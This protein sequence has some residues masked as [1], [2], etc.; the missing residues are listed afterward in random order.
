MLRRL[1]LFVAV[2]GLVAVTG[3]VRSADKAAANGPTLV[4]RLRSIDDILADVKYF[5]SLAGREADAKRLDDH[6]HSA[7]PN[8]IEGID[9]K[10]PIG[11]YAQLDPD[12]NLMESIPVALVPLKDEKAFVDLIEKVAHVTPKLDSDGIYSMT[13]ENSPVS[14]YMLI[15]NKYAYITARE[16]SALSKEKTLGPAEVFPSGQMPL[17]SATFRMDQ[18]PDAFKQIAI[19]QG[20][21]RLS[22]VEDDKPKGETPAQHAAKV[23]TAKQV[24]SGFASILKEGGPLSLSLDVNPESGK[25][26]LQVTLAARPDTA[27][28]KHIAALG[29]SESLFARLAG[30]DSAASVLVHAA[31]PKSVRESLAPAIDEGIKKGLE[32]E[33]DQAKRAI[34]EKVLKALGPTLKAGELDA[35]LVLSGPTA[36]HHY[37]LLAGVKVKDGGRLNDTFHEIVNSIPEKDRANI[38]LD[39]ESAGDVKIHRVTAKDLD[40]DARR[41]FGDNPFFIAFRPDAILISGGEGGLEALKNGLSAQPAAAP[42]VEIKLSLS[43]LAQTTAKSKNDVSRPAE[44]AFG[45][46]GKDNDQLRIVVQ[47][48]KRLEAKVTMNSDVFKFFSLVDKQKKEK[49]QD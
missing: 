12:G 45:G 22:N 20:E 4:V 28:A 24:A 5:A 18:I 42:E 13:P 30:A 14:V 19:S 29:T 34:A 27:L 1:V 8:G 38:K 16:K 9:T 3:P 44:K 47:G 41:N 37:T 15:S 10:R 40:A 49:K 33:K 43:R 6:I 17:I 7:F 21:L 2:F 31:L 35:S 25:L 46:I 36:D 23:Q 26:M 11:L 48:G 39:A 32:N